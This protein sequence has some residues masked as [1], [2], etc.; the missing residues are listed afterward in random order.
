MPIASTSQ[1]DDSVYSVL[2]S[3]KSRGT[4]VDSVGT[5]AG[6]IRDRVAIDVPAS[7]AP[8]DHHEELLPQEPPV[9][10]HASPLLN[11][12]SP[13]LEPRQRS[14]PSSYDIRS[15]GRTLIPKA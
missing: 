7:V 8:G 13:A 9:S 4:T 15:L 12:N 10:G 3:S 5:S 1:S 11:L 6:F 2:P 14:S